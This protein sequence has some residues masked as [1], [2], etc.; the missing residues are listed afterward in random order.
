MHCDP[1]NV[2]LASTVF[3]GDYAPWI[4]GTATPVV[5]KRMWDKGK[6][7]YCSLGHHASDFNVQEA[8]TIVQRGMLWASRH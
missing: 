1:S 6:V 3:T 8:R 4:A 5:W 2:V 7:F